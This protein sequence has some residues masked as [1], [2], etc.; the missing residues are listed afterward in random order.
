MIRRRVTGDY[1]AYLKK[2]ASKAALPSTRD[3]CWPN[4]AER[5]AW[6]INRFAAL[7]LS[8]GTAI[9][10]GARYGEEVEAM[11]FLGWNA[12]GIDLTACPPWVEAGDM[13][14]P[15]AAPVDLIYSNAFD[16]CWQ[17][18]KFAARI[19]AGLKP[20]GKFMLHIASAPPGEYETVEW[21]SVQDVA[22]LFGASA[23]P[24]DEFYGLD[25]EIVGG[26]L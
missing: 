22:D 15:L 12:T 5:V 8:P 4:R 21:D 3:L 23:V 9:C 24:M 10:L 26:A 6:F 11:R 20:G 13:N 19:L 18:D 1:E 2:Q 7:K 25:T 17:P 16:H 14:A